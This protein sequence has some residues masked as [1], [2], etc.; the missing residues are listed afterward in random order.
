M[1]ERPIFVPVPDSSELVR[2]VF[3]QLKWHPGFAPVQKEKNIKEFY[4]AAAQQGFRHLLEVS[5]K[6]KSER[7]RHLSAF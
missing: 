5:S 2:E 4:E 3:V 1:A 6:S 7:G